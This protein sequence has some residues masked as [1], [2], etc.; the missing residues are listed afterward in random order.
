[1]RQ[2]YEVLCSGHGD[3]SGRQPKRC[4]E[5]PKRAHICVRKF[6]QPRFPSMLVRLINNNL[7]R[8]RKFR[9]LGPT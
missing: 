1:M 4:P 5:R 6:Y 7:I 3:I 9:E 2:S 8:D